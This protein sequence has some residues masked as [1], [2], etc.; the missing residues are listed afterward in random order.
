MSLFGTDQSKWQANQVTEGSF[1]LVKATEGCGYVDPT[2]D[3]KYQ[4]N[5]QAGKLLG[6]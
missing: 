6:V 5:K 3:A 4:L 2:C 1:I